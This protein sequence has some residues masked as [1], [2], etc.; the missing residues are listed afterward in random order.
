MG[1]AS[2]GLPKKLIDLKLVQFVASDAHKPEDY[3]IFKKAYDIVKTGP[4]RNTAIKYSL[5]I[6]KSLLPSYFVTQLNYKNS[7]YYLCFLCD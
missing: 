7:F 3:E 2:K 6:K 4:E 5:T 1:Q